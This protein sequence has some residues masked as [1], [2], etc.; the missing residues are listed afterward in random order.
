MVNNLLDIKRKT[1]GVWSCL[2]LLTLL[3]LTMLKIC[4]PFLFN[5]VLG[6]FLFMPPI[7]MEGAQ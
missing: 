3:D 2:L 5:H 7:E 6:N 1:F 4:Y